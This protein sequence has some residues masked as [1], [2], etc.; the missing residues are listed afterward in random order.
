MAV[1]TPPTCSFYDVPCGA[2]WLVVQ[3]ETFGTWLYQL[4]LSGAAS[5]V[6]IIPVPLFLQDIET[7]TIPTGVAFFVEPFQLEYGIGIM[8]SAYVARFILRRIPFIG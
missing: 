4:F 2:S 5:L 6:E 3:L 7:I 1:P 8:V